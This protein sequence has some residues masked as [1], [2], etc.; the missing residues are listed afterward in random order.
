MGLDLNKMTLWKR[1]KIY[2][3]MKESY[4]AIMS[5]VLHLG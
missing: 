1:M 4:E 2:D 3:A 5:E